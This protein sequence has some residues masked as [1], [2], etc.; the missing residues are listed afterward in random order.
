MS[1]TP[2]SGSQKSRL[3]SR[4]ETLQCMAAGA[5]AAAASDI[6]ALRGPAPPPSE[7]KPPAAEKVEAPD[8][9]SWFADSILNLLVDYY[10]EV[11]FRPYGSGATP[12]HVEKVLTDLQPGYIIIYAKGH[13]GRTTFPSSLKTEHEKLAGDML[14]LFRKVTRKTGTRLFL[15]YSGLLDGIA[16]TRHPEW[17]QQASGN[18]P[19]QCFTEF[20]QL[21]TA[22]GMCPQS[23]YWDQWAAVHL[24]EMMRY[25][26]D[27]IWVDGDWFGPCQCARCR[28]KDWSK[29]LHEWHLKFRNFIKSRKA[30]CLYSAGN[31]SA[32][33]EYNKAFD[34]R[35][36]DWFS[37][38]NHRLQQSI[39]MRRYTNSGLP[40]DAFTCDTVFVHSR[41]Q[42]R[43][44]TKPLCRMLQE[45]AGVMA[46]GGLWGYWTYPMPHGAFVPSRMRQAKLAAEF[47]RA[48]KHVFLHTQSVR[49][50]AILDAEPRSVLW[51]S[52]NSFWG[53]GKALIAL[54]RS[55]DVI[56][57]SDLAEPVPY[58][59]VL[60]PNQAAL[61]A[62][63]VGR[64]D[65]FVKSGGKLIS[66]GA[67]IVS[68]D[69]QRLLGVRLA[70]QR[71]VT[72]GH[73]LLKSNAPA[74]V[75]APWDRLELR[76][77]QELYPLYRAWDDANPEIGRIRGSYP[78]TGAVDEE[79]PEPAGFPA[80]TIRQ[81]GKGLAI[82]IATNF[83]DTYWKFGN[84]DMLAWLREIVGRAQPD[85]L[86]QT[87]APSCVEVA[88]RTG[89]AGSRM[90]DALLVHLVNGNPGR[91]ISYV[92]NDDLWVD[93]IPALG[94]ITCRVRCAERPKTVTIEPGG[95]VLDAKWDNGIITAVAPRLE[96]HSCLVIRPWRRP[97]ADRP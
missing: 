72:D 87:D 57:E 25:E 85:P 28:G 59:L 26:P 46:N 78:I 43:A 37:P 10:T 41:P 2:E 8:G 49:W 95:D 24:D 48:R 31:V 75:Y 97:G 7:E 13:S 92:A 27:G 83:F 12:D 52:H 63:T 36:G 39:T 16:G 18:K 1:T 89:G 19:P 82:H 53:A 15:Y 3:L 81:L 33:R 64:L 55:P 91:D 96:I 88:L 68:P 94:P 62:D 14:D 4:R 35:S 84:P 29:I 90:G 73:V 22:Y 38:N 80:A 67:S 45:G 23:A 61:T 58:D 76:E 79:N 56:E 70:Q 17:G 66:E 54:H 86:F 5:A 30:S 34:W 44:R 71:A 65:S 40:Y 93:D 32:R 21:F 6:G 77:A 20:G 51:P 9:N 74:G 69:L 60:V 11:P 42:I 47:A 50:T